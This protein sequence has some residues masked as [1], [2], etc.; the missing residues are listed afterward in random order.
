MELST[1]VYH[2]NNGVQE[3]FIFKTA[4]VKNLDEF[5]I[6]LELYKLNILDEPTM[7]IVIDHCKNNPHRSDLLKKVDSKLIDSINLNYMEIEQY[8]PVLKHH[9]DM[10]IQKEI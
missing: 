7:N 4:I 2:I 5:N 3:Q 6:L 8:L 10:L 1:K 9:L